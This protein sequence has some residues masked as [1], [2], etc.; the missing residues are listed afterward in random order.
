MRDKEAGDG[1]NELRS[2]YPGTCRFYHKKFEKECS[3]LVTLYF[4][5]NFCKI[6]YNF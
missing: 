4:L 5:E 2:I 1:A 6:S 3:V